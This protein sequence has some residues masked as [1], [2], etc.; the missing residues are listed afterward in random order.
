METIRK[1]ASEDLGIFWHN[2]WRGGMTNEYG[3]PVGRL[4]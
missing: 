4:K 3:T 1:S 2:Q